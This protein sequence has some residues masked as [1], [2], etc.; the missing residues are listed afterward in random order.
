MRIP[1]KE[2][3]ESHHKLLDILHS[4]SLVHVALPVN[5]ALLDPA[6]II[7]H[8]PDSI[9]PTGKR[10]EKKYYVPAKDLEVLVSHPSPHSMVVDAGNES[11]RQ[12][13]AKSRTHDKDHK[14]LDIPGRKSYSS[15]SL[16][17]RIANYQ[18]LAKYNCVS[19][20]KL[21]SFINRLPAEHREQF[22]AIVEEGQLLARTT[23]QASLDAADTATSWIATAVVMRGSSWLW[24]CDFPKEVQST[25]GDLPF[26]APKLFADSIDESL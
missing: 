22:Q 13:H 20:N 4:P 21:T 8:T 23:F 12:H 14:C 26:D 1:L 7:W 18:A 10:M 19:Y 9:L 6:K 24:L 3:T 2:V 11:G 16:Q 25:V 17:L 5:E 15:S